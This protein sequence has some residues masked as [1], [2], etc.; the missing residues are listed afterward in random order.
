[1]QL[2]W[3]TFVLEIINFLILIWILQHFLYKPVLQTIARRKAVIEKKLADANTRQADAEAL[4]R[5]YRE[6]LSEWEREKE[7][8]RVQAIQ[9]IEVDRAR[10]MEKLQQTLD[11]ES[12][13]RR[14]MEERRREEIR[15]RL[16]EEAATHGVRFTARLLARVATPA[17][18]ARLAEM[19]LE[20]LA[21]LPPDR[22]Q[23]VRAA[24]QNAAQELKVTSAFPL[25]QP[26]RQA[27]IHAVREII[28]KDIAAEFGEDR[29]LM[30]GLRISL[31]PWV[32]HANLLDEL[33]FF[34]S[35][36]CH[37]A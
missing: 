1:M 33:K 11:E 14:A 6:R 25:S 21:A 35:A 37:G 12:E 34:A 16:K 24:A 5:K 26:Q 22:S 36:E 10:R 9:E 32:L 3:L 7:K 15:N 17:L 2:D 19:M 28:K 4:E 18:E 13:K 31:G 29:E 30:A 23:A 27:I 8:L 20:D